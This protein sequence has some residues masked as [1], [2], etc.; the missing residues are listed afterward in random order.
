VPCFTSGPNINQPIDM[1]ITYNGPVGSDPAEV[2][3]QNSIQ[4]DKGIAK[5]APISPGN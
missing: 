2:Q 4:Q 1:S 3:R 5:I